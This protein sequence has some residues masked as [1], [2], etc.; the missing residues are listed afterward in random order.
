VE[1]SLFEVFVRQKPQTRVILEGI[2]YILQIIVGG[3]G[4]NPSLTILLQMT[5]F[6]SS[7]RFSTISENPAK[8]AVLNDFDDPLGF[9]DTT[10]KRT[11]LF[12]DLTQ[13]NPTK[14][15]GSTQSFSSLTMGK[16][17]FCPPAFTAL[18]ADLRCFHHCHYRELVMNPTIIFMQLKHK[19]TEAKRT[20]IHDIVTSTKCYY[21]IEHDSN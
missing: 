18:Q 3:Q 7:L 8:T 21:R 17:Q 9:N 16:W 15:P 6:N 20:K 11:E 13:T 1:S 19:N 12:V 4:K 10:K 14:A 5:F 2:Q